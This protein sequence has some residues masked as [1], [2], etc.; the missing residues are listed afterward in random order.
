MD[1]DM[2][3]LIDGPAG[4]AAVQGGD[5][6]CEGQVCSRFCK[7]FVNAPALDQVVEPRA[8][9]VGAVAVVDKES[10]HRNS[11]RHDL[12]GK[13]QH[14]AVPCEDTVA[15]DAAEQ[16]SEV[17]PRRHNLAWRNRNGGKADIVRVRQHAET[18]ATVEGDVEL[19]W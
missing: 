9:A 16:H 17:D 8:L 5:P 12:I 18:T 6:P 2:A 13:E 11:G 10:N 1:A 19:A 7:A 15:G 14:A 4:L 3:L